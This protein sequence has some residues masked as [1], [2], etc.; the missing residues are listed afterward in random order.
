MKILNVEEALQ[1]LQMEKIIAYPTETFYAVGGLALSPKASKAV[2]T[3]KQR[4]GMHP[5]PIIIGQAE[6]LPLLTK[7]ISNAALD[8]IA[9]FWPGPLSVLFQAGPLLP[10]ELLCNSPE[11]AIRHTPHNGAAELCGLAGPLSASSANLSGEPPVTD[12]YNLSG[13]LRSNLA[14]VADLHPA[15]LGGKPSTLVRVLEHQML[16]ILRPWA[17][18]KEDLEK[19]GWEV[20]G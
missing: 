4:D 1:Q 3:A 9:K 2:F 20:V 15:P 7:N 10:A 13:G 19:E 17:I 16:Q 18:T 14:G 12:H 11:A 5:L 6:Q 8:L